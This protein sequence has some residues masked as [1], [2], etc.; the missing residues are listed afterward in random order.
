MTLESA[1]C[2]YCGNWH[3]EIA[4]PRIAEIEYHPNGSVKRVRLHGWETDLPLS[5]AANTHRSEAE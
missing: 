5:A 4:C 3:P 2:A 1:R